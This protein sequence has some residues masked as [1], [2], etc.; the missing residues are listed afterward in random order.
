MDHADQDAHE[1]RGIIDDLGVRSR[2][3]VPLEVA[4]ARRGA[5]L[6]STDGYTCSV[7]P[8]RPRLL[9]AIAHWIRLTAAGL[10]VVRR[11]KGS[12][13]RPR[14]CS[15]SSRPGNVTWRSWSIAA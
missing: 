10:A 15:T 1:V 14:N 8:G 7:Q 2:L 11:R 6:A 13:K 9:G 3:L 12:S 4:A 5:L